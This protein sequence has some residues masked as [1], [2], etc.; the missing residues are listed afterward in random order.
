MLW[1]WV[2]FPHLVS[3]LCLQ[4]TFLG[5]CIYGWFIWFCRSKTRFNVLCC[6]VWSM[7]IFILKQFATINALLQPDPLLSRVIW[8][9]DNDSCWTVGWN[10]WF[11]P[12]P[13]PISGAFLDRGPG[14]AQAL[15]WQWGRTACAWG[16]P[17]G[18]HPKRGN[19]PSMNRTRETEPA[20]GRALRVTVFES[21][22]SYFYSY[23]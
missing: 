9:R 3:L 22:D 8:R 14:C 17:A 7:F 19:P 13:T 12:P 18:P 5:M 6:W 20:G 23:L 4:T 15:E 11:R 21:W 1:A 10:V 2:Q 16:Q